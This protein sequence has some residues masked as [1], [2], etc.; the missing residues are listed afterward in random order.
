M[1]Q[2]LISY[3]DLY[4]GKI[5]PDILSLDNDTLKFSILESFHKNLFFNEERKDYLVYN[6]SEY[7][8]FY[9]YIKDSFK[10]INIDNKTKKRTLVEHDR[11][12]NVY[13]PNESS[14]L[15]SNIDKNDTLN[16]SDYTLIYAVDVVDNSSELIIKYDDNKR[17]DKLWKFPIMNNYFF[18]FPSNQEYYI[19]KNSSNNIN[20]YLTIT[21]NYVEY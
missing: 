3:I 15:R 4:Y 14:F 11:F 8:K 2:N 1:I 6:N 18:I 10:N 13:L 20:V 5:T 21:Y 9:L 12:S 16:S 17:K 19:T 7:E